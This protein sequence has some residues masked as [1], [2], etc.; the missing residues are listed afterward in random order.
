M[1]N[2]YYILF[3]NNYPIVNE[4]IFGNSWIFNKTIYLKFDVNI[5]NGKKINFIKM[6]SD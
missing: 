3:Q 2:W 4:F 1:W 5:R 6:D